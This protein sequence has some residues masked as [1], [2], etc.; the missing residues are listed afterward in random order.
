ML[1]APRWELEVRAELM[2]EHIAQ[3]GGEAEVVEAAAK[4]GGG[5]LALAELS[6]A[7]CAVAPGAAGVDELAALLREG[8]PPL[9]GRVPEGRLLLDPRTLTDEE[10]RQATEAVVAL[11]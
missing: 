8:D 11:G 1:A 6:G 10:A 9:I 2:R 4:A 7:V 3:A 5:A